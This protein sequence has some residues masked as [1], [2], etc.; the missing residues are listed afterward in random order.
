MGRSRGRR[1]DAEEL[2]CRLRDALVERLT[3]TGWQPADRGFERFGLF[4]FELALDARFSATAEVWT[5]PDNSHPRRLLVDFPTVGVAFEP[6]RRLA[7]LLGDRARFAALSE[8]VRDV[9]D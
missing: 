6:L 9:D 7:P 8:D 2:C 1:S 5:Q 4:A 3:P